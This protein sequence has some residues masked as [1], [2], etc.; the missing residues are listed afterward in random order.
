[1]ELWRP[2]PNI[3]GWGSFHPEISGVIS[4]TS[5]LHVFFFSNLHL[6]FLHIIQ[7]QKTACFH[8]T[9]QSLLEGVQGQSRCL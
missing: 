8:L 5:E 6:Y 3:N 7:V 2:R 1:M 9:A 4:L